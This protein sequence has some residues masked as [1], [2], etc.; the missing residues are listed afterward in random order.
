MGRPNRKPLASQ[1]IDF[2]LLSK[3]KYPKLLEE[4]LQVLYEISNDATAK[5]EAEEPSVEGKKPATS[6]VHRD[7]KTGR[8][9]TKEY[10]KKHPDTTITETVK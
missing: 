9:V 4:F 1:R 7:A 10:T 3:D 6:K 5:A 8:F 2:E